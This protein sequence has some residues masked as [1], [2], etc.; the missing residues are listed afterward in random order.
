MEHRDS[1][2]R[3][4]VQEAN[5]LDIHKT[6]LREIQND[7]WSGAYEFGLHLINVA[8]PKLPA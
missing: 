8:R 6:H 5:A 2:R 3:T 1:F 7:R 4:L